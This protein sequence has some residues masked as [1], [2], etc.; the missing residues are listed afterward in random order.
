[1][2][3]GADSDDSDEWGMEELVIPN[4]TAA[5]AKDDAAPIEADNDDYW[6]VEPKKAEPTRVTTKPAV[7][8]KPSEPMI[9]VDMTLI[10]P[11]IH[12]KHDK[13]SVS[14]SA[15]ASALRKKIETDYEN[16]SKDA[17]KLAEGIVI[18]CGSSVWREAL[19]RLRDE[20]PGHYFAPIFQPK[21]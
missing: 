17:T 4:E 13:N 5:D 15:K 6:K 10:D 16:Y 21:R 7:P 12:S 8:I 20:R 14:D 9:I 19:V 2:A 3:D 11:S 18:P 1:M